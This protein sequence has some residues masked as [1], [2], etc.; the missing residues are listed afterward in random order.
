MTPKNPF[1]LTGR[2]ALVTGG[3]GGLGRSMALGFANAGASVAIFGRKEAKNTAVL[4]ELQAVGVR[5][6]ALRVDMTND[7]ERDAAFA[8]V[9]KTLGPVHILVNNAGAGVFKPALEE[10][11]E[12]WQEILEINLTSMFLLS[13]T[14]ALS[15]LKRKAGKIINIASM[16]SLFGSGGVPAYSS[17]KGAVVQ[18][19]KSLAIEFA[20]HHI[21]VNAIVPGFF[22]T[23]LTA[24]IKSMPLYQE[25]VQRTPAGRWGNPDECAGAA[26]FLA[27]PASD[28][29]TGAS[30]V[31]DG[32]YSIY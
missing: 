8:Q 14:A 2:V 10:T 9:E 30:L 20:P 7:S 23:E 16:Y 13:K 17:S 22:E 18:L 21:Q 4:A 32:G 1:D 11:R 15:M 28:F 29:V 24:P 31:V 27:A 26:V 19:T 3:N 25:V 12:G 6:V 5:A